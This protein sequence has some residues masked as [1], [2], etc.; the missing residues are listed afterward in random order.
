M[1]LSK[2]RLSPA[3]Q[4][5][6]EQLLAD[7][8]IPRNSLWN[9][10]IFVNKKKSGKWHLL[11]DHRVVNKTMVLMGALQPGLPS[12]VAIPSGF[13]KTIIYLKDCF[14]TIPLHPE[15]QKRFAS[16]LPSLNFQAPMQR[17]QWLILSQVMANSPIP[18]QSFA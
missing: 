10:S 14:F 9:R 5:V 11:R 13:L 15:D 7:H 2:E 12:P 3:Q 16:S 8:I 18:C 1:A 6:Q 4:L 17:Y